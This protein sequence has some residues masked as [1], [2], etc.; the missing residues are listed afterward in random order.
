MTLAW[1]SKEI[2]KKKLMG[3]LIIPVSFVYYIVNNASWLS[4]NLLISAVVSYQA[5]TA[6][7]S[8]ERDLL[9]LYESCACLGVVCVPCLWK[10]A[11][12]TARG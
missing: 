3:G 9:L 8:S 4:T 7:R 11:E 6:A 12:I 10:N 2:K 1:K 5:G